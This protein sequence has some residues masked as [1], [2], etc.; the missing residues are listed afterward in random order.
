LTVSATA[1]QLAIVDQE[2]ERVEKKLRFTQ[3]E[4]QRLLQEAIELQQKLAN[5]N[6]VLRDREVAL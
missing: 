2:R 4:V 5:L 3:R 6:Q 1:L